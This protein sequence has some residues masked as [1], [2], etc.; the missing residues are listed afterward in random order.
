MDSLKFAED[1]TQIILSKKGFEIRIFD[2][3]KLSAFADYFVICS[4]SSDTQVKAIAD[5]VD[6]EL[7]DRGI[8]TYH[9]EGYEALN[10]VLLDYFDV[11]VHIFK[12]EARAFYN[13]E[14]LWGDA[15]IIEIE[16]DLEKRGDS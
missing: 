15:D 11:V 5:A 10:W 13:L 1:I 7:R 8:K 2:L 3:K 9:K 16:D 4:A 14:K 6:K 12:S